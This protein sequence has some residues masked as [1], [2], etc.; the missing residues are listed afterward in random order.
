MA[1]GAWLVTQSCNTAALNSRFNLHSIHFLAPAGL[2]GN[3]TNSGLT[4]SAPWVSPNH[5]LKCGD[6]ILALPSNSANPYQNLNFNSG[7]WGDVTCNSANDVA[8]L[9]CKTF[10]TC[11]LTAAEG[12]GIYIDRSYWG[13]QGFNVT[14]TW[15]GDATHSSGA[16][17]TAGPR[18]APNATSNSIHHVVFANN[19]ANGCRQ[20]G[21]STFAIGTMSVD[22][23]GIVGNITYNAA[24]GTDECYSGISVYKP[25]ASDG[26]AGTHIY[27]GGNLS[28]GNFDPPCAGL[29]QPD[30]GDGI[31]LDTLDGVQGYSK[32][33]TQQAV[34]EN[35]ILTGNGAR[36]LEVQNNYYNSPGTYG[37]APV[38][39]IGNTVTGN[40]LATNESTNLCDETQINM[41]FNIWGWGN[42]VAGDPQKQTAC[43]GHWTYGFA[44][45]DGDSTDHFDWNF[46]YSAGTPTFVW[47]DKVWQPNWYPTGVFSFT[48]NVTGIAPYVVQPTVPGPPDCSKYASVGACIGNTA[49]RFASATANA[50]G[51]YGYHAPSPYYVAD[52]YFPTWLCSA[53][54]PDG[55]VTNHCSP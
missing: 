54:L 52:S 24:Q 14:A 38:F 30:G 10:G 44:S 49:T 33:Y 11:Q 48:S 43:G 21:I 20:G 5:A 31:I 6:I 42:L 12:P 35:N 39:L 16:C 34:V 4:S 41:G 27:I 19:I 23:I 18:H 1:K 55:L 29:Y 50:Y 28:Y 46:I 8:W 17:F 2:G 32:T 25:L 51:N 53:H 22:Y 9:A 3:D 7:H 26:N 36:G 45:Y 40:S 13:V 15:Y 47:V 37:H